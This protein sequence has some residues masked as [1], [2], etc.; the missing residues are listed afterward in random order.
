MLGFLKRLEQA[1]KERLEQARN[2]LPNDAAELMAVLKEE[3][4]KPEPDGYEAGTPKASPVQTQLKHSNEETKSTFRHTERSADRTRTLF[5][6][7]RHG[8]GVRA[9][10]HAE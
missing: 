7:R 10:A 3:P 9:A 6:S 1:N 4:P 2:V 8:A 5:K